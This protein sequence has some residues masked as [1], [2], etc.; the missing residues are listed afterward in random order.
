MSEKESRKPFVNAAEKITY[1][2]VDGMTVEEA[3]RGLL[4][5]SRHSATDETHESPSGEIY[6]VVRV[7]RQ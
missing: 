7:S 3:Y 1:F 2:F 6:R 5:P 4:D